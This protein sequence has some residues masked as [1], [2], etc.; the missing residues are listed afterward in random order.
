MSDELQSLRALVEAR[1][2]ANQPPPT[3]ELET[4]LAEVPD[5]YRHLAFLRLKEGGYSFYAYEK[6]EYMQENKFK[7]QGPTPAAA[8]RAALQKLNQTTNP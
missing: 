6:P 2:T 7:G 4:M 8:I 5:T 1:G 3:G